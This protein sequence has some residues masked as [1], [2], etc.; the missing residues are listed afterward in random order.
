[1][2]KDIILQTLKDIDSD[3]QPFIN[4]DRHKKL[5]VGCF[6][7]K[8][9]LS[10][11]EYVFLYY[12]VFTDNSLAE[13][14]FDIFSL[15][16][17]IIDNV[18]PTETHPIL[19]FELSDYYPY[20]IFSPRETYY[21]RKYHIKP[22]IWRKGEVREKDR[23]YDD[24]ETKVIDFDDE[25][26]IDIFMKDLV[27]YFRRRFS[28]N[29]SPLKYIF[30]PISID[31]KGD[32]AHQNGL[33]V[34]YSE[35]EITLAFFEPA[36]TK[37][38]VENV[39]V[40]GKLLKPY[41]EKEFK[42]NVNIMANSDVSQSLGIQS[43]LRSSFCVMFT[44]MWFY[45]FYK[46]VY[47]IHKPMKTWLNS[48]ESLLTSHVLESKDPY[49]YITSFSYM[50]VQEIL[51]YTTK[52]DE[53]IRTTYSNYREVEAKIIERLKDNEDP[54]YDEVIKGLRG[55]LNFTQLVQLTLCN[56]IELQGIKD[57]DIDSPQPCEDKGDCNFSNS[58]CINKRCAY[59]PVYENIYTLRDIEGHRLSEEMYNYILDKYFDKWFTPY[60]S[61]DVENRIVTLRK[62]PHKGRSIVFKEEDIPRV[63]LVL[64]RVNYYDENGK[65]IYYDR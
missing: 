22:K 61:I 35:N 33:I 16:Q 30:V 26:F 52:N 2:E 51:K 65:S 18:S 17:N 1:M 63:K 23:Y 13:L 49:T 39:I 46:C 53:Y 24:S 41:L 5:Q 55:D 34:E 29:S 31:F 56:N 11:Q 47:H 6:D 15:L 42:S 9:N 44:Y 27:K 25:E 50:V 28:L 21:K 64:L 45:L 12:Q 40:F 38:M 60:D 14:G 4:L 20:I 58:E 10:L 48:V 54:D 7:R 3:L 62:T 43:R 36:G 19:R 59:L 32:G 8:I 37:A 57:V